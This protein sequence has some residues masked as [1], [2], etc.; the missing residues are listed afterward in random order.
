[1]S[2]DYYSEAEA[3]HLFEELFR[4]HKKRCV[5]GNEMMDFIRSRV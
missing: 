1:M 3:G 5:L 4:Y 2:V